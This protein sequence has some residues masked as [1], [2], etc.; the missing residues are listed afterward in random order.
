MAP[1][2]ARPNGGGPP[3]LA[4]PP[5][6]AAGPQ[7]GRRLPAIR[8]RRAELRSADAS[9]RRSALRPAGRGPR[10]SGTRASGGLTPD[11][12]ATS[13]RLRRGPGSV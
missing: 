11:L 13:P 4:V 10:E 5:S 1:Q 2:G 6:R 9:E 8:E 7:A 12:G 3:G